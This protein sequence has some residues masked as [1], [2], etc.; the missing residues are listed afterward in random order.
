M[1]WLRWQLA[2]ALILTCATWSGAAEKKRADLEKEFS[3]RLSKS[4]LV[5][6][7]SLDGQ[8][9]ANGGIP[10]RYELESVTKVSGN[11]WTFLARIKYLNHDVKMPVTVPV[12]WAGDTPMISMTDMEIPQLGTFT[13]RVFFYEDRYAGTWQHGKFGGH[14]W[15]YVE[16]QKPADEK[17]ADK[18]PAAEKPPVEAAQPAPK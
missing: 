2:M 12:I 13:A 15:G 18:E 1:S 7:F 16:K 8:K 9:S 5:G 10:E 14:M 4:V 11:L 6:T 17:P 3:E